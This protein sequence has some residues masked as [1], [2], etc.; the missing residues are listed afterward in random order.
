MH[1]R[2]LA[3]VALALPFSARAAGPGAEIAVQTGFSLPFGSIAGNS[4]S[5]SDAF[6]GFVPIGAELGWRF[7]PNLY[8][9]AAFSYA[10]GFAKNCPPGVSCS[11]HD[12]GL[13]IDV[14]Y[15]VL[16]DERVDPWI[17]VGAGYEWLSLSATGANSADLTADGFEFVHA[18]FGA[19]FV[20]APNVRVGPFVQLR[21]GEYK[22]AK[23]NTASGSAS[24]DFTDKTLHEFLTFGAKVRFLF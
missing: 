8:G 9:G 17:G 1:S 20:A 11:G 16:P 3:A 4:G 15:H 24:G 19:D 7:T 21:V 6:S 14:R 23:V 12:V 18:D 13:G 2:T 5:L 22:G 10:F